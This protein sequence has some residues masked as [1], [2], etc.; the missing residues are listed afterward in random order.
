MSLFERIGKK[1][2]LAP[3]ILSA[4]FANLKSELEKIDK[5]GADIVHLDIMDGHF[6]PN[7][8]FGPPVV[9]KLRKHSNKIFDAHLMITNPSDF[10]ENFVNSGVDMISVHYEV[11]PHVHRL[12]S[13][14]KESGVYAGIA[15][16]P[17]TPITGLKYL[18][19]VMD[20][21]L[22]MSVNPGFGGQ[23]FINGVLEKIKEVRDIVGESIP[24]EIDGG[25]CADNIEEVKSAGVNIFVAGSAFFS[26]GED[27]ILVKK[28]KEFNN[29]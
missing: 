2:S 21:V 5:A 19:D 13:K 3:S 11:D 15:F 28:I 27:K 8:T 4:D 12:L 17:S 14:I 10:I 18:L 29:I 6:V 24:I 7:L 26:K 1:Y 25:I 23:K 22:I 9:K 16:N 20:F